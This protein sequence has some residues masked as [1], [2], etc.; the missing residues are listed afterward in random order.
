MSAVHNANT[1]SPASCE[2]TTLRRHTFLL[3]KI[4]HSYPSRSSVRQLITM[5]APLTYQYRY[6]TVN[7]ALYSP[8]CR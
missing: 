5:F 3:P 2:K 4:V 1:M 8:A 7:K 6:K